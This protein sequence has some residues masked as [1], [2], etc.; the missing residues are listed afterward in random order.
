LKQH[1]HQWFEE[2]NYTPIACRVKPST[3]AFEINRISHDCQSNPTQFLGEKY[4]ISGRNQ[5]Q[6]AA[7]AV[8]RYQTAYLHD[9]PNL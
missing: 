8:D 4:V 9:C 7:L 1:W 6:F 2:N 3:F 5:F